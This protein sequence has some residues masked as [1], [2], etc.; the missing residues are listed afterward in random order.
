MSQRNRTELKRTMPVRR[1]RVMLSREH[2]KHG[3]WPQNDMSLTK[4]DPLALAQRTL[5]GFSRAQGLAC[6][7]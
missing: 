1:W 5:K 7:P 3:F 4:S 2:L 6:R